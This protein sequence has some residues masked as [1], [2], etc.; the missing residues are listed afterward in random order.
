MSLESI[1]PIEYGPTK[2]FGFLP[3]PK[4]L[5]HRS[6]RPFRL[7]TWMTCGLSFV[8]SF[9]IANVYYCQ[10]LLIQISKTFNVSYEEV[11]I[12]P[13][14]IQTG[15]GIAI[16]FVC[17]LG[18]LVRRRQLILL[19]I[20]AS[21]TITIA[22]AVTTNLLVF[23]VFSFILGTCS[24][25]AQI[26]APLA[27]DLAQPQERSFVYSIVFTGMLSGAAIAR[28]LAGVV[29]QFVSWR[30]IYDIAIGAQ[31]MIL[32]VCYFVIPD[33]PRKNKSMSY[34]GILW[35]MIK[36]AFTEPIVVQMEIMCIATSICFMNYWVTLTYLLGGPPYHYSTLYIGLFGLFGFVGVTVSPFSG[37]LIDRIAPWWGVLMAGIL[38]V[39]LQGLHTAAGGVHIAVVVI[40]CSTLEGL[41]QLQNV[42][43][44]SFLFGLEM[45]A[46]SRLNTLFVLSCYIGQLTGTSTST[47]VFVDYGWRAASGLAT[48]CFAFLLVILLLRGPHC[49]RDKWFGYQGGLGMWR[50]RRVSDPTVTSPEQSTPS[51]R[52]FEK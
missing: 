33:Y 11:A 38:M 35:S 8:A 46:I 43:L 47:K 20:F 17:P 37:R 6:D 41:R 48:A 7:S 34:G 4:Y 19:L 1:C 30:V 44:I 28:V 16:F 13:T 52:D 15:Y 45:S 36:Y 25:T 40:T 3:I 49:P 27:A 22:F 39:L 32:V 50:K 18:D 14:L 2:D 31:C 12:I 42:S 23:Q 26:I 5:Q 24:I 51:T 9:I 29:G 21:T 10:P